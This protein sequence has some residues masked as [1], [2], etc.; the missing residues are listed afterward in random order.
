[1]NKSQ[2]SSIALE[3]HDQLIAELEK[4]QATREAR[5]S[6]TRYIDLCSTE[7][8]PALHHRLVI[9][10]LEALERGDIPNLMIFM[11]PGSAK[12]YYVGVQ[13][14]SWYMGRRPG[15]KVIAATYGQEVADKWGRRVREIVRSEAYQDIFQAKLSEES[16]AAARFELSTHSEY[17]GIGVGGAVTSY[18]ADLMIMDDLVKGRQ[19]ADSDVIRSRLQEWYIND[20]STRAKPT[21]KRVLI[22]T[23]WR[24]DDIA[25][26]LLKVQ[27][28][29]GVKWDVLT[30]PMEA[31]ENDALGRKPGELLWPEWFT[32]QMV[33]EH[34]ADPR[35]W[36]ALYQQ[37]P[38]AES[39]GEFTKDWVIN[40]NPEKQGIAGMNIYILVDPAN[41]KT[42]KS[43]YTA[44]AIIGANKDGNLYLID[45]IRDRLNLTERTNILFQLH[46]K[47]KPRLVV[48]EQY[49]M[50]ADI[51][52][53]QGEMTY[54]NYRFHIEEVGGKL[55]KLDRIRRLIPWFSQHKFYIPNS[56]WKT[57]TEGK[58]ID[59][60]DELVHQEFLAFPVG[61][62]DDMLDAISRICDITLDFPNNKSVDYYSLYGRTNRGNKAH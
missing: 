16:A 30:L 43:D 42:K 62:H 59:V 52:H 32:P 46:E 1:M 29:T 35:K 7:P 38:V 44:I 17:Y 55:S 61:L 10:K 36:S 54:R 58:V 48:Y 57:N 5:V 3:Q 8:P 14:A 56:L 47:Y 40:W 60:I 27:E 13:F 6:F 39:G 20:L 11:P 51:E 31:G 4:I 19:E 34:K 9:K 25:A 50:Q 21:C 22:M 26:Y 37:E 28:I 18:R 49:G 53:L 2:P 15:E 33:Q 45:L 23:R 41:S 24:Y 12:S